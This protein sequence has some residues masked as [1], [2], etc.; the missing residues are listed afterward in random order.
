MYRCENC[1]T[2]KDVGDDVY[3]V[4]SSLNKSFLPNCSEQCAKKTQEREIK[5]L[6]DEI[7]KIKSEGII[8]EK[9]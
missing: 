3:F 5:K 9:W 8:K 4:K 7:D 6:Q 2:K 1:R